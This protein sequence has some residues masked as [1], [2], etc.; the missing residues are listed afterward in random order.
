MWQKYSVHERMVD[1]CLWTVIKSESTYFF[2]AVFLQ[3][4]S[5][6]YSFPTYC[7][8]LQRLSF[9]HCSAIY[10][11]S[12]SDDSRVPLIC[13][14]GVK[15]SKSSPVIILPSSFFSDEFL[16]FLPAEGMNS[17]LPALIKRKNKSMSVWE[18]FYSILINVLGKG[19]NQFG[20]YCPEKNKII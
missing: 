1:G 17:I 15:F 10:S 19:M 13:S 8:R 5:D 6:R 20:P 9:C 12:G 11:H 18:S 4:I 7:S 3:G 2:F 16:I 14:M